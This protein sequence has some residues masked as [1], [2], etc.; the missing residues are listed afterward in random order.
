VGED[1]FINGVKISINRLS[2][3][4]LVLVEKLCMGCEHR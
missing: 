2:C 3:T 4:S 1:M